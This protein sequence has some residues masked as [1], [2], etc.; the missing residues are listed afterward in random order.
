[1]RNRL[2]KINQSNRLR[3]NFHRET[4]CFCNFGEAENRNRVLRKKIIKFGQ[5]TCQVFQKNI[6]FYHYHI[7]ETFFLETEFD[8]KP[9]Q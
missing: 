9:L 4:T 7:P 3:V 5:I 6:I 2:K 1:M 8:F